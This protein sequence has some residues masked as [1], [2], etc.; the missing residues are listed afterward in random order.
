[1]AV[2][3][4]VCGCPYVEGRGHVTAGFYPHHKRTTVFDGKLLHAF[5][6]WD[7]PY[8]SC[9]HKSNDSGSTNKDVIVV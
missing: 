3:L 9:L 5:D 1:M 6:P 4:V 7:T 2:T 8:F